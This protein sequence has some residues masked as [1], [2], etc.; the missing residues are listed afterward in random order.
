M[1]SL[2]HK[3]ADDKIKAGIPLDALRRLC[4]HGSKQMTEIYAAGIINEYNRE[5]IEK[6]PQFAKVIEMKRKAE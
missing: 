4:G 1:Y 3:G 2:K 6:S 5:I